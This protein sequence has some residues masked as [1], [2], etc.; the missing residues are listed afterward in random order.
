M[1]MTRKIP[2][3]NGA[4]AFEAAARRGSIK[5]AAGEL[6]VT[7]AA[8][9]RMVKLLEERLGVKL[10]QRTA[11]RLVLTSAGKAYQPGLTQIFDALSNLTE[12]VTSLSGRQVLTVGVGPTFATK[13]LI[14]RLADFQKAAPEIDVH[15]ATGGVAAPYS[16]DWTCGI[17]LGDGDW[18]GLTSEAIVAADLTP[19]CTPA[20]GRKLKTVAGL[21]KATLLRVSHSSD[22]WNL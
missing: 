16:D 10:F 20:V 8:V 1:L 12:Q 6:N 21:S 22:D 5:E 15:I 13:W 9:S 3:L 18:P 2:F 4:R 14:P 17:T 7:P 11:N 19:V